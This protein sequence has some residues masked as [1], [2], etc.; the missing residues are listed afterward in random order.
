MYARIK[1]DLWYILR[2]KY[3]K[4]CKYSLSCS[5]VVIDNL[6]TL[7]FLEKVH[8]LILEK[9]EICDLVKC[10]RNHWLMKNDYLALCV[11][12]TMNLDNKHDVKI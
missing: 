3:S 4:L 6:T 5:Q 11:E 7:L 8:G 10:K 12:Q 9:Y 1:I 2:N